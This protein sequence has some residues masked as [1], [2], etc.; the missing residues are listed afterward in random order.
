MISAV[1]EYPHP[2]SSDVNVDKSMCLRFHDP[3][4]AITGFLRLTNRPN[5][6]RG[7]HAVCIDLPDGSRGFSF[8]RPHVSASDAMVAAGLAVEVHEPLHE[9]RVTVVAMSACSPILEP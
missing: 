8:E 3:A 9:L 7:E 6:G 2:L 1:R 5:K 4:R